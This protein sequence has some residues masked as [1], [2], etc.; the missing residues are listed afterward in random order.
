MTMQRFSDFFFLLFLKLSP[1][2]LPP[3]FLHSFPSFPLPTHL[4]P[5]SSRLHVH[6][7]GGGGEVGLLFGCFLNIMWPDQD[8]V[9]HPAGLLLHLSFLSF[10]IYF[11][12]TVFKPRGC[13]GTNTVFLSRVWSSGVRSSPVTSNALLVSCAHAVLMLRWRKKSEI[14][15]FELSTML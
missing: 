14:D 1:D 13:G 4:L 8:L 15:F 9:H 7:L 11:L 3:P 2:C 6:I 10:Y 5:P 12:W